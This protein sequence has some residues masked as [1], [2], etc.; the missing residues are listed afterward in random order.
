MEGLGGIQRIAIR[1]WRRIPSDTAWGSLRNLHGSFAAA[2]P[3]RF[4]ILNEV[5][6][7]S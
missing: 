6:D 4:V 1:A 5:K 3:P 2:E 7:P